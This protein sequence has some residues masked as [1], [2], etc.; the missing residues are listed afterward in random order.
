MST[1][2]QIHSS[3]SSSGSSEIIASMCA[4]S[5]CNTMTYL[6][7]GNPPRISWWHVTRKTSGLA[8][9]EIF[10]SIAWFVVRPRCP[11][12]HKLGR[13]LTLLLETVEDPRKIKAELFHHM[14]WV[15]FA[16]RLQRQLWHQSRQDQL[17][18]SEPRSVPVRSSS[19]FKSEV[20]CNEVERRGTSPQNVESKEIII[21]MFV[22]RQSRGACSR[23]TVSLVATGKNSLRYHENGIEE[24]IQ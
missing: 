19:A 24:F 5:K 12:S 14:R 3:A 4:S 13:D 7:I 17:D 20:Y 16:R 1:F 15:R 18:S 8:I 10:A 21:A 6:N 11:L 23:L 9:H 2:K 22:N